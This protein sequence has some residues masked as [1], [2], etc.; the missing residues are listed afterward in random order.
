MIGRSKGRGKSAVEEVIRLQKACDVLR[1]RI[2]KLESILIDPY[3]E[4]DAFADA[5]L[6]LERA[7][8]ALSESNARLRA[9]E[10]GLGIRDRNQVHQLITNPFIEARMNARALKMR[11]RDKLRFRKF[12][13]DRLERSFRK[14]VNGKVILFSLTTCH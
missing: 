9:K 11:L 14:Q 1:D 8:A 5:E 12:E 13:L 2:C 4:S 3:T 7:Q 10:A 6:G